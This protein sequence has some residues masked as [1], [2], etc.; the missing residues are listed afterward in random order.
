MAAA[1]EKT[2]RVSIGFTIEK[3]LQFGLEPFSV[4]RAISFQLKS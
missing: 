4:F 1:V 2:G 3:G